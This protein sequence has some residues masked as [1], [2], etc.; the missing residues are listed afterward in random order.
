MERAYQN[1]AQ[2]SLKAQHA[3][4]VHFETLLK[5][6]INK[7]FTFST[8]NPVSL[9]V[10]MSP[11]RGF[12]LLCCIFSISQKRMSLVL[13]ESQINPNKLPCFIFAQLW[14]HGPLVFHLPS[15]NNA[16]EKWHFIFKRF[17]G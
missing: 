6:V 2:P 7:E 15:C 16:L 8:L 11:R 3:K 9:A 14:S 5:A 17:H 13:A 1:N 10:I 12:N 4:F